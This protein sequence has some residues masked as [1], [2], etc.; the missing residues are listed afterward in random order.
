MHDD[1]DL[2][3]P[4][5]SLPDLPHPSLDLPQSSE[6]TVESPETPASQVSPVFVRNDL[7]TYNNDRLLRLPDEERLWLLNNALLPGSSHKYPAK[8][9]YGKKRTFQHA[10][11]EEFP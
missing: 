1:S 2:P 3:Q 7:G 10:W 6:V 4:L 11:L 9:E 8:D 5:R